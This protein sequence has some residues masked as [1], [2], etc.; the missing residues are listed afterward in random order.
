M[1]HQGRG[2]P[3]LPEKEL[4]QHRVVTM[5]NDPELEQLRAFAQQQ[6]EPVA[7]VIRQLAVAALEA[8]L[9]K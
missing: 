5:L 2:R 3:P 9:G 4:R 6:G 8:E 7:R 1:R